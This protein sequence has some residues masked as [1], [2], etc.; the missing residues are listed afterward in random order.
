MPKQKFPDKDFIWTLELAYAIGLLVTDGNLSKDGRHINFRSS[1]TPLLNTFKNCLGLKNKIGYTE[2]QRGQRVQFSNIQFYNWLLKIGLTPAK[3]HT[4]GE[5]KIPNLY[6]KDFLRGHLDG[7]GSITAYTDRY[8]F[9]KGRSYTNQRIFVRFISASKKHID[10]LR[11]KITK[12]AGVKGAF[13]VN[14]PKSI[15]HV[16]IYEIKFA[17]KESIKLLRWLYYKKG[18]PCLERKRQ[19]AT[20][21]IERISKEKR[22]EYTRVN[23]NPTSPT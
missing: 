22:R 17:K 20:K 4:I 13:I 8:N 16:P 6:F 2:G 15:N 9:Y 10:W 14:K 7:D 12:F 23:D 21:A 19:T 11:Q 18:I 3:T 1:E 5:I